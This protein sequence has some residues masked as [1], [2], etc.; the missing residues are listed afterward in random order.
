MKQVKCGDG[1][2]MATQADCSGGGGGY[3]TPN[4]DTTSC[5][6]QT[7]VTCDDGMCMA[8]RADCSGGGE[9]LTPSAG[10]NPTY[11]VVFAWEL[12]GDLTMPVAV[13]EVTEDMKVAVASAV[14]KITGVEAYISQPKTA[15]KWARV[16]V[17]IVTARRRRELAPYNGQHARHLASPALTVIKYAVQVGGP[18]DAEYIIIRAREQTSLLFE[19]PE[20]SIAEFVSILETVE[21]K[22]GWKGLGI[23][24]RNCIAS[25]PSVTKD[26]ADLPDF[27]IPCGNFGGNDVLGERCNFKWASMAAPCEP[28]CEKFVEAKDEWATFAVAAPTEAEKAADSVLGADDPDAGKSFQQILLEKKTK[29]VGV[30]PFCFDFIRKAYVLS[31]DLG[32]YALPMQYGLCKFETLQR[33]KWLDF[34]TKQVTIQ[35][36]MYNPNVDIYSRINVKFDLTLGGRIKKWVSVESVQIRNMYRTTTDHIRLVLEM[37]FLILLAINWMSLFRD[38]R[39][40]GCRSF[41]TSPSNIV[42]LVGQVMYFGNIVAWLVII[43]KLGEWVIPRTQNYGDSYQSI[44]HASDFFEE[45][46][47]M[48]D[49]YK[50]LNSI[51]IVLNIVRLYVALQ[52]HE[53][54]G[55][56]TKTISRVWTDMY[57]FL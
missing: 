10:P 30:D 54:L 55:L 14:A 38:L 26:G 53:R 9:G 17:E 39:D 32:H 6:G 43:S 13:S 42:N 16:T 5:S 29:G 45:L 7:P 48:F 41:C 51:S 56:V 1:M 27:R 2:C 52:F 23:V 47:N 12:K 15:K 24:P 4:T 49:R 21:T 18:L 8:T 31:A 50:L 44:N 34:R 46:I 40:E 36:L 35:I 3:T 33:E 37:L 22:G 20:V 19:N 25:E 28:G 57:H 11:D